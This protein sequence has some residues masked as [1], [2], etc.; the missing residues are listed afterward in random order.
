VDVLNLPDNTYDLLRLPDAVLN[1]LRRCFADELGV[2]LVGPGGVALYL[3][4]AR[5][6]VLYNLN[7]SPAQVA[8]R[9]PAAVPTQG[10]KERMHERSLTVAAVHEGEGTWAR[11]ET[12]VALTLPP[13]E[14][15]LL[16]AP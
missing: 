4:G 13:F 1:S 15:A 14:I 5:Q 10:W 9:V 12:E 8:L 2:R 6:F 3:S 16:E 11:H 7:D